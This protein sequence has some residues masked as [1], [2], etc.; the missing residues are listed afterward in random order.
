M[1]ELKRTTNIEGFADH[2][3]I[4]TKLQELSQRIDEAQ[5][6]IESAQNRKRDLVAE[7]KAIKDKFAVWNI[8]DE[9]ELSTKAEAEEPKPVEPK[10]EIF[11]K[12]IK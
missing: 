11:D 1:F 5:K 6:D 3:E 12:P 9:A 10:E 2:R 8:K 4:K 7:R